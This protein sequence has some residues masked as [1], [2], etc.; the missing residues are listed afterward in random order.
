MTSH[1]QMKA[2][3]NALSTSAKRCELRRYTLAIDQGR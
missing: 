1:D 2:D 3:W